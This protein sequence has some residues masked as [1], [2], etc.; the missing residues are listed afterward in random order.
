MD[1]PLGLRE[2]KKQATRRALV[3]AAARL[4][5]EKGYAQ[6]TVAEIAEAAEVSTTTMFNYFAGKD[7]ILFASD[8]HR[9]DTA[10]QAIADRD[11][12][13]S[14]ADLLMRLKSEVL[15]AFDPRNESS[16]L[17]DAVRARL[18]MTVPELQARTLQLVFDAQLRLARAL[19]DAYPEQLDHV[20]AAGIVG[21]LL[22]SVQ[23]ARL[24]SLEQ[25]ATPEQIMSATG[26][27]V[28]IALRGIVSSVAARSAEP[29]PDQHAQNPVGEE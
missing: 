9:L 24:A 28:D 15:V 20:T 17:P 2:R 29:F 4:F 18:V 23:T 6:T 1:K 11:G 10:V 14:L 12:D 26:Q 3:T 19:H 16:G 13:E 8:R 22:G 27:A 25:G 7:D 5:E 21:A